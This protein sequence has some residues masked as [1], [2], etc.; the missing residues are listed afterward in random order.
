MK[1][2][3]KNARSSRAR[4]SEGKKCDK[5]CGA[6]MHMTGGYHRTD[7]AAYSRPAR[8]LFANKLPTLERKGVQ[9]MHPRIVNVNFDVT[10]EVAAALRALR[11]T[12]LFG[13]G[14]DCASVAE[15]LLRR[16]L[17]DSSLVDYWRKKVAQ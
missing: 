12:G 6:V 1:R 4:M 9:A 13:N 7:C 11:D 8:G 2:A 17:L 14:C 16:A 10:Q 5:G 3:N 15:E